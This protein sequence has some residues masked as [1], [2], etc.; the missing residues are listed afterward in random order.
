M[1]LTNFYLSSR[2]SLSTFEEKLHRLRKEM[3][4][5]REEKTRLNVALDFSKDERNLV[6]KQLKEAQDK[7]SLF[8]K[9]HIHNSQLFI[10]A[11]IILMIY[12]K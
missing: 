4:I 9:N 10:I 2:A 12:E 7:S 6:N 5:M 3:E 1:I 8:F 11:F